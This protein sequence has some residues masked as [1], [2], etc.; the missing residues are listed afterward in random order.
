MLKWG[1]P[2]WRSRA[3]IKSSD[4]FRTTQFGNKTIK[5]RFPFRGNC[6][7]QRLRALIDLPSARDNS[8]SARGNSLSWQFPFRS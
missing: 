5:T 2:S 1:G 6:G 7:P 3:R 8:L 4:R